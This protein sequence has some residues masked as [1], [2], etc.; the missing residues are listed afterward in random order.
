[1]D[2]DG[3][4]EKPSHSTPLEQFE[5]EPLAVSASRNGTQ[6]TLGHQAPWV[7]AESLRSIP[8]PEPR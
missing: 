3:A 8:A 6:G 7:P 4:A 2:A 5:T 1:M